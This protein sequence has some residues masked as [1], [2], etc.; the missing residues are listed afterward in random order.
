MNSTNREGL[1][2]YLDTK[3]FDQHCHLFRCTC[4]GCS[5]LSFSL[6][7]LW[8]NRNRTITYS[9]D[10]D[11]QYWNFVQIISW[12]T[13]TRILLGF[14]SIKKLHCLGKIKIFL[15]NSSLMSFWSSARNFENPSMR[16]SDCGLCFLK[17]H[18]LWNQFG[19]LPS[20]NADCRKMNCHLFRIIIEFESR[21]Y[22]KSS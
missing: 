22:I 20:W 6:L 17:K 21:I 2:S 10:N 8:N 11:I 19:C 12:E 5:F 9:S 15:P 7:R 16:T 14:H 13:I 18:A 3:V 1:N 4:I